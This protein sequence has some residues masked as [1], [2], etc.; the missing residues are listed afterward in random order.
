MYPCVQKFRTNTGKNKT[1]ITNML[2]ADK[3]N[4]TKWSI[5]DI[6]VGKEGQQTEDTIDPLTIVGVDLHVTCR[7]SASVDS[8]DHIIL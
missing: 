7:P 4:N 6:N 5:K 2:R 8:T 1:N 3:R